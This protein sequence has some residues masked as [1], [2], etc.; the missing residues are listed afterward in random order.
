MRRARWASRSRACC[1]RA[2]TRESCPPRCPSPAPRTTDSP[3]RHAFPSHRPASLGALTRPALWPEHAARHRRSYPPAHYLGTCGNLFKDC[4][5][6]DFD[7]LT[8]LLEE[9]PTSVRATASTSDDERSCGTYEHANTCFAFPS[10]LT[11]TFVHT[12][13]AKSYDHRLTIVCEGG[14]I[15]V[16]NADLVDGKPITFAERFQDSYVAQMD[17][18]VRKVQTGDVAPNI[19]FERTRFLEHLS[20]LAEDSVNADGATLP[21]EAA[22]APGAFR[23]YDDDTATAV[24][25]LYREMRQKQTLAHVKRLRAKYDVL[26]ARMTPWEALQSLHCYVDVSD[27]DVSLPNMVHLFQTAEGIREQGLPDW[28]QLTGLIHDMGKC[29]YLRGCD[30]DGTCIKKQYSVVGDTFVVGCALPPSTIFPEFNEENPDMADPVLSTKLG[31]YEE[32]CGLDSVYMAY[33]HDEYLYQVLI[34][35]EGVTLPLE[36]LYMIRYHSCYPWHQQDAYAHLENAQDRAMKGW[37]K[38]FNQHDLYTKKNEHFSP[39]KLDEMRACALPPLPR[40]R[41]RA[42]PPLDAIPAAR[43]AGTTR[44]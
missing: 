44:G 15:E 23:V 36:A 12:R 27:P 18:F 31:V 42:L 3:R 26:G 16:S 21:L 37:V 14:T 30:E 4:S 2:T 38:L 33:G 20:E 1:S 19:S 9:S 24:R 5:I 28:M 41:A 13:I 34:Q 8:W 43:A 29:I 25:E 39:E 7:Y 32:G 6:H 17:F 11:A 35:N 10:G 40:A 22:K